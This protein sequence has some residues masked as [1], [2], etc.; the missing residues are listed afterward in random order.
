M[1]LM[2]TT[3]FQDAGTTVT[4]ARF[5]T[6]GQTHALSGITSVSAYTQEPNRFPPFVLAIVGVIGL[7]TT[8]YLF[9]LVTLGVAVLWWIGLKTQYSVLIR[10]AAGESKV[11]T[12]P[13]GKRVADIVAA[14]NNAIVHRG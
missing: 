9:G 8:H 5:M 12:S 11:L 10:T 3:F 13:D 6:N 4:N 2:E 14:L 1:S 7:V